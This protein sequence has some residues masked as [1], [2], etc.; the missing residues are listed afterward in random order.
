MIGWYAHHHGRGHVARALAVSAACD[1]PLTVFSSRPALGVVPLPLDV[2]APRS[3]ACAATPTP[4]GLHY[5]PVGVAGVRRRMAIIAAWIDEVDPD[6]FVVDVSVEVALLVRLLGV[7]S[8]VL[9]QHGRRDD[10]AHLRAYRSATSLVAPYPRWLEDPWVPE[11]IREKT[12]YSGGFSRFDG[13]TG[14]RVAARARVGL[15][16]HDRVVV[17]LPGEGGGAGAWPVATAAAAAP[18]W[19]WIALGSGWDG[20][21]GPGWVKDPFDWLV[22]ADVVVTHAG[23]NAVMECA[24]VGAPM[25]VIPQDRP[26]DEQGHKAHRLAEHGLAIVCPRWPDPAAWPLILDTA[27]D[28]QAGA[29][30]RVVDGGSEP[31]VDG[32]GAR[33]LAR[34]LQRLAAQMRGQSVVTVST[35]D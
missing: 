13:R 11:W 12:Y 10:E 32:N 6:L 24:A 27:V 4:P 28:A 19:N 25:V 9:R 23:H 31:L 2:E 14:E 16:P 1:E 5:A 33:R 20:I 34:H 35:Q 30:A 8:V 21:A 18:A 29:V 3:P 26:Y 7:P 22:A 15:K 17:V